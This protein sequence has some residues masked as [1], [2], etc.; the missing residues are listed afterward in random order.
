MTPRAGIL[1]ALLLAGVCG[2]SAQMSAS[3][4]VIPNE[5]PGTDL[6]ITQEHTYKMSGRVRALLLWIGRDDVGSGVIRWRGTGDDHAYELLIGSDPAKAPAKLNKWGFLAEEIRAGECAVVGV[7]SKDSENRLS[8]VKADAKVTGRPFN[9]IRGRITQQQG[10]AR[11]A[12]L[13]A[14][15]TFT[16][17]E[18]N[19]V[20]KLALADGS[21]QTR[22]FD[23]PAGVRPGFLSSMAEVLRTSATYASRGVRIPAS[24]VT[25]IYGDRL[26]ELRLLDAAALPSFERD[27]RKFQNV[28]RGR[29]ETGR[30]GVRPGSRFELVF[31]TA[32]TFAGVPI[33]ISYQP[34]WWL[35]VELMLQT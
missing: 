6:P 33:L 14:P 15:N 20:L 34:K 26:Y 23:R 9:T 35:H 27:G 28:I 3:R 32:G 10:Y 18:A 12:V 7:M 25:Y 8:D 29:F 13:D 19:A 31:G 21:T 22:T 5:I 2:T 4:E 17:R 30:Q 1:V 11:L 24:T 16:Y